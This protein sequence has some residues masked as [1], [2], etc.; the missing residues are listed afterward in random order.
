[1][2][3]EEEYLTNNLQ[4]RLSKLEKEKFDLEVA[5]EQEQEFMV[6]RLTKQLDEAKRKSLSHSPFGSFGK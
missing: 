2:E 4:K 1:M 6:N 5:M 3:Q